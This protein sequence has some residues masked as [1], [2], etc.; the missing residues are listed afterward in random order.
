MILDEAEL[1]FGELSYETRLVAFFDILGW[2][3]EIIAAGDDPRHIARLASA[4]RLFNAN[5]ATVGDAGARLT[6]FSDN[7]VF[8]KPFSEGDVKWLLQSLAITQLGLALHGFWMR[9]AVTVGALHHDE[10]IVFGPALNRAYHL[11]SKVARF[12]RILI[13]QTAF[14]VPTDTDFI[15]IGDESFLDPFTPRFWERVQ[16]GSPVQQETVDR[17][18]ELAGTTIPFEPVQLPGVVA[19]ANIAQRLNNELMTTDDPKV[20]DKLAW[21][22]DRVVKSLGGQATAV[23]LPKS[24]GLVAAL[25]QPPV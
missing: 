7:V 4:V 18:N 1:C 3:N 25:A 8:S 14:E 6:T 13:D 23:M 10:H 21:L 19:L 12:P 15:S 5:A 17:F 2:K 11:E 24:A 9:G 20:W 22:F 16:N